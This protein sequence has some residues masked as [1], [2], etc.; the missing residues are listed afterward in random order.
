[1]KQ[2]QKDIIQK[3]ETVAKKSIVR[4]KH[5]AAIVKKGK[6]I[7]MGYNRVKKNNGFNS[8]HAERDALINCPKSK[9][10]GSSLYVIRLNYTNYY[11]S[12]NL[13][14]FKKNKVIISKN[15]NCL[16]SKPCKSCENLIHKYIKH[17]H[18]KKVYY[19]I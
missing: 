7:S 2:K 5:A 13:N 15:H 10:K 18:L 12:H 9:I 11:E 17:Y 1:M 19:T 3:L 16:Y 14:R 8:I 4:C 6:I